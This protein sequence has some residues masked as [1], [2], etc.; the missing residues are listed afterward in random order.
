M[1]NGIICLNL[2]I[3]FIALAKS[4]K[5]A[6]AHWDFAKQHNGSRCREKDL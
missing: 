5:S 3:N 6:H 2:A 1:Q 4:P